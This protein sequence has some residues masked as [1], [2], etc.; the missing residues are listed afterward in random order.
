M[1]TKSDAQIE[2]ETER[3]IQAEEKVTIVIPEDPRVKSDEQ[4]WEHCLN[5]VVYRY[6]RGVPVELPKTLAETFLRK[7]RMQK[8]SAVVISTFKGVGKKLN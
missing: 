8:E 5:G 6:P 7:L 2:R 1:P 3:A 4:F